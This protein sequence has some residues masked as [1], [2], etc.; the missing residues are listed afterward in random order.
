MTN[1]QTHCQ[2][3]HLS[4]RLSRLG[5]RICPEVSEA[6]DVLPVLA[7]RLGLPC[8]GCVTA[9]ILRHGAT[10]AAFATDI[11]PLYVAVLA[12]ALHHQQAHLDR[13]ER[14]LADEEAGFARR[15]QKIDA[16]LASK[17]TSLDL[18]KAAYLRFGII[19]PP[20]VDHLP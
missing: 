20:T 18:L 12:T 16:E 8:I 15:L 1:Q 5:E 6:I 14:Q 11:W 13:L 2:A 10:P 9:P 4:S 3:P 19:L 7:H 17:R